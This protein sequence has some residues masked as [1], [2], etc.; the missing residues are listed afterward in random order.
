VCVRVHTTLTNTHKNA[1]YSYIL[2]RPG[3]IYTHV[4]MY[5]TDHAQTSASASSNSATH[6]VAYVYTH[7]YI[8]MHAMYVHICM[9][10][11]V[12]VCMCIYVLHATHMSRSRYNCIH[13]YMSMHRYISCLLIYIIHISQSYPLAPCLQVCR[14]FSCDG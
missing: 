5:N 7:I 11:Y 2:A 4:Y 13:M 9:C 12:C 1:Q 8:Y 14:R 10:S 6:D 3:Y